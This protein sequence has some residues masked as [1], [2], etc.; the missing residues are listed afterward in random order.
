[1]DLPLQTSTV[2]YLRWRL[3]SLKFGKLLLHPEHVT[4]PDISRCE[5]VS[6]DLS[7]SEL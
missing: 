5:A 3:S 7:G 1:M 6:R 4:F 2:L